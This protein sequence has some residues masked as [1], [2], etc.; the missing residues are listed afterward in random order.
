MN[1][2]WRR[3]MEAF[4]KRHPHLRGRG[5]DGAFDRG[6]RRL[7][8]QI[9][10]LDQTNGAGKLRLKAEIFGVLAGWCEDRAERESYENLARAY[11]RMAAREDEPPVRPPPERKS[12]PRRRD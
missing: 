5:Q 10:A 6:E 4:L 1:D 9:A 11:R 12:R 3:L 8:R 2:E 7:K